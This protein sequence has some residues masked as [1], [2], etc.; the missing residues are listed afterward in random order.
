MVLRAVSGHLLN[1]G[2]HLVANDECC[3][4]DG[5]PEANTCS[6][7]PDEWT[8]VVSGFTTWGGWHNGTYT[9]IKQIDR[10]GFEDDD[11]HWYTEVGNPGAELYC[12][13]GLWTFVMTNFSGCAPTNEEIPDDSGCPT[14][15]TYVLTGCGKDE[16]E[17]VL[18]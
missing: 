15:G 18:S 10:E 17:V 3:C 8:A 5:C 6:G 1:V 16:G 12:V 11:C 2:G 9:L 4:G 13:A 7:C 14:A